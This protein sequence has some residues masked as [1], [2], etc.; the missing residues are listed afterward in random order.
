DP[1]WAVTRA[2]VFLPLIAAENGA[3]KPAPAVTA[4]P[5]ATPT[6]LPA[7]GGDFWRDRWGFLVGGAVTLLIAALLLAIGIFE[8]RHHR[9]PAPVPA[10][11][12]RPGAGGKA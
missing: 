11:R 3:A 7:A 9:R 6:P 8:R 4:T 5:T 1:G 2:A 10:G 12:Q